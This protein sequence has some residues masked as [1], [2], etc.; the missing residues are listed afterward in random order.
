RDASKLPC[1][2]DAAFVPPNGCVSGSCGMRGLGQ[3]CQQGTQ[4]KSGICADGVC[5]ETPSDGQCSYCALPSSLGRCVQVPADVPDPRAAAGIMDPARI[6][7]DQGPQSC[8]T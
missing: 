6:C 5:C 8:G 3:S 1:Q 2:S 7:R 4:C